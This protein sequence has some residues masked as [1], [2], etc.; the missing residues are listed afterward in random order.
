MVRFI[1]VALRSMLVLFGMPAIG[2]W[3]VC[4]SYVG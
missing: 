2:P 3:N 1:I 4:L